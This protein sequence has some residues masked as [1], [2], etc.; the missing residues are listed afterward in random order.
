M[1]YTENMPPQAKRT[2]E[3]ICIMTTNITRTS[4][5]A[6]CQMN[7]GQISVSVKNRPEEGVKFSVSMGKILL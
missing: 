7:C 2:V 1:L 4:Q 6:K 3:K 5:T